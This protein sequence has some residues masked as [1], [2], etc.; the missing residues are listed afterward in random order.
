MASSGY[1]KVPL[2]AWRQLRGRAASAPTT[3]FT[4]EVVAA[5]AGMSSPGSAANNVVGPMRRLG[6]LDKEGALTARGNKWRVDSSYAEA[7]QE[8]LDDVYPPDLAALT[9]D[10]GAPDL[11][12]IR[13][14][15]DHKGFGKS[16]AG[17]MAST[18]VMIATKEPQGATSSEPSKAIT[19]G[20]I[21]KKAARTKGVPRQEGGSRC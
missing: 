17:Q 21:S 9:D 7:C 15:F 3:K 19:K 6:L 16:N 12:K 4:P 14:W 11:E 20:A 2:K 1:P 10:A 8:I 18:Y 5:L 13:T